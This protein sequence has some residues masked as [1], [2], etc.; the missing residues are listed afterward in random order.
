MQTASFGRVC[1][2]VRAQADARGPPRTA[3]AHQ[4]CVLPRPNPS[5][6]A[7]PYGRLP[8]VYDIAVSA[9]QQLPGHSRDEDRLQRAS[10]R[11][12]GSGGRG[13]ALQHAS[14]ALPHAAPLAGGRRSGAVACSPPGQA[15]WSDTSQSSRASHCSPPQTVS[16]GACGPRVPHQVVTL[17]G[18]RNV[19]DVTGAMRY[20]WNAS[21][22]TGR[23]VS[24]C[25]YA[26]RPFPQ[27]P[28]ASI[29]PCAL[30]AMA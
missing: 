22:Y 16:L 21:G 11:A 30:H 5:Q 17:K 25:H 19:S 6:I 14:V 1:A 23:L 20:A 2:S 26:T 18:P 28:A 3:P 27:L 9:A 8:Y 4:S 7:S 24:C 15:R 29:T 13:C 10:G 12:G